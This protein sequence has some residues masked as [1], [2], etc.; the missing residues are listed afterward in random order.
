M[1]PLQRVAIIGAGPAGLTAARMLQDSGMAMPV[2]FEKTDRIG[3]KSMT[4]SAGNV[5]AEL[6][7]CYTI[8]AHRYV[9][10]LCDR[11]G[12]ELSQIGEQLFDDMDFIDF[13]R[14]GAGPP[15]TAQILKYL[16]LQK[17]LTRK[18]ARANHDARLLST[19]AMPVAEWLDF[20][21]LPKMK[22]FMYRAMTVMGYGSLDV[23]PT[24]HALRWCNQDLIQSGYKKQIHFP[25]QGWS[26]FWETI[27]AD[28]EIHVSAPISTIDRSPDNITVQTR[29]GSS[30]F[31]VLINTIPLHE[32]T[33]LTQPTQKEIKLAKATHWLKYTTT[34]ISAAQWYTSHTTE[35]YSDAKDANSE[36]ILASRYEGEDDSGRHIYTIGQY[37][38]ET[39]DADMREFILHQLRQKGAIDPHIVH[40]KTWDYFPH[41]TSESIRKGLLE[42]NVQMQGELRTWHSG[43]T[44]SHEAISNISAH[45]E[46]IIADLLATSTTRTIRARS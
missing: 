29:Q 1:K 22:R 3:G 30:E 5:H 33:Q 40:Q 19:L 24:I 26:N 35:G 9:H 7:T 32:F 31:D 34:T 10:Y 41:Y 17:K 14:A 11:Y 21:K 2:I 38:H 28:L 13:V 15:L 43:A 18:V 44:L 4:V 25:T 46:T 8:R 23:T 39:P 16:L 36:L 12:L 6:G 45:N 37:A 42:D 20:H 27:S